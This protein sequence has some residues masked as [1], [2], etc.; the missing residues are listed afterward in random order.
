MDSTDHQGDLRKTIG[1]AGS[2]E[3]TDLGIQT[4]EM[5]PGFWWDCSNPTGILSTLGA[6]PP[7]GVGMIAFSIPALAFSRGTAPSNIGIAI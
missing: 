3:E 6:I 4:G 1:A 2:R 7:M 5:S